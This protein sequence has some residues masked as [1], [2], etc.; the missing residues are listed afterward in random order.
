MPRY[1]FHLRDGEDVLLDP[2]GM[3]LPDSLAIEAQA[4]YE[5]RSI[6]SHDVMNGRIKLS[7]RIDV[8]NEDGNI[9]HS[10]PFVDAVEVI[11]AQ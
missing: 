11:S 5:A 3:E 4:L 7:Q 6:L 10:I 8:E 2:K 1:Y 9:V